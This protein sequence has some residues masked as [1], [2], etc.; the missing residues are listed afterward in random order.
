M[1]QLSSFGLVALLPA[2]LG[3]TVSNAS[4]QN[5]LICSGDGLVQTMQ[6]PLDQSG[7]DQAPCGAKGCHS[8]ANRKKAGKH[9]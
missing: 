5:M 1:R 3:T 2:A 4:T 6:V 9:H 7:S 8:G